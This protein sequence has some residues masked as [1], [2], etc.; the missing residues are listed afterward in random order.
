[1]GDDPFWLP[2]EE[3]ALSHIPYGDWSLS[4]NLELR[5]RLEHPKL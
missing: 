3:V 5:E 4:S 1:M 2:L